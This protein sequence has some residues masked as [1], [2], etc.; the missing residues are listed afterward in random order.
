M[1]PNQLLKAF[2]R[3]LKVGL[4]TPF[5]L[6]L[7]MLSY[8][9]GFLTRDHKNKD[10]IFVSTGFVLPLLLFCFRIFL[11]YNDLFIV[12]DPIFGL[13]GLNR[14]LEVIA[15][16]YLPTFV[17]FCY[18]SEGIQNLFHFTPEFIKNFLIFL[19]IV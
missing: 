14:I 1:Y 2:R 9:H 11:W 17:V 19:D 16:C 10:P 6:F 5:I 12:F 4:D 18:I 8:I 15:F 7:T 3:L 13:I